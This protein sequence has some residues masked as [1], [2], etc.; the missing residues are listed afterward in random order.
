MVFLGCAKGKK[1]TKG[2]LFASVPFCFLIPKVHGSAGPHLS[3]IPSSLLPQLLSMNYK[4]HISLFFFFFLSLAGRREGQAIRARAHAALPLG[5]SYVRDSSP[6][7]A[8]L[9]SLCSHFYALLPPPVSLSWH[10]L[11]RVTRWRKNFLA[12]DV[13]KIFK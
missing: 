5:Y 12:Q 9:H 8:Y 6:S 4:S 7:I 11:W 3:P 10:R 1:R 13:T 2:K